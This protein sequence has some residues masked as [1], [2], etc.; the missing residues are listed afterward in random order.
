MNVPILGVCLGHQGICHLMGGSVVHAPVPMH[1]RE[2]PIYHTGVGLFEGIPNPFIAVRY[3]S[4]IVP[5]PLPESL[6]KTAWTAE[7]LIMGI[8]HKSR[9][10]WGVQ[11]HPESIC[12]MFG[13]QIMANFRRLAEEFHST[14]HRELRASVPVALS[15]AIPAARSSRAPGKERQMFVRRMPAQQTAEQVF[16]RAFSMEP[17]AFWLDSSLAQEPDARFSFLGGYRTGASQKCG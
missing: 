14:S 17:Y 4:L 7:G 1:G 13:R 9:P 6:N 5:E 12:S 10:M 8:A 11:F 15:S 16:E 2:R 3:H